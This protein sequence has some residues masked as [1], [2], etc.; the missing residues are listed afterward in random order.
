M[1]STLHSQTKSVYP[2]LIQSFPEI[3]RAQHETLWFG[4]SDHDKTKQNKLPCFIDRYGEKLLKG[5]HLGKILRLANH[6]QSFYLI[7]PCAIL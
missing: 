6:K 3:P 1:T 2:L 5:H 7:G 4:I